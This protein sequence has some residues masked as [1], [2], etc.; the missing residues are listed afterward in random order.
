MLT[1]ISDGCVVVVKAEH[2]L[3]QVMAVKM[4]LIAALV[5]SSDLFIVEILWNCR[6]FGSSL[7]STVVDD[8]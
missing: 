5:V 3:V 6:L 4:V 1:A 2:N 8:R 7:A